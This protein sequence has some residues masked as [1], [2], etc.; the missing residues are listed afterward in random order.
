MM[1]DPEALQHPKQWWTYCSPPPSQI[2]LLLGKLR[3][4]KISDGKNIP[5]KNYK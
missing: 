1:L 4:K 2:S 3:H 5:V